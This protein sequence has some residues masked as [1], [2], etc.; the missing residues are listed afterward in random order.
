MAGF[1]ITSVARQ[2]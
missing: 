1:I 2:H